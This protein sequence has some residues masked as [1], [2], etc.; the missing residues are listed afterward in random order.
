MPVFVLPSCIMSH[1]SYRVSS[2]FT[3]HNKVRLVKAGSEYFDTLKQMIRNATQSIHVQV[4]IFVDDETGRMI[5]EELIE[6]AKRGINVYVLT[7]GYASKD[8]TK[9]FIQ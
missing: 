2:A 1:A 9:P 6:A 4:Y 5:A 7:D 3:N 8:L